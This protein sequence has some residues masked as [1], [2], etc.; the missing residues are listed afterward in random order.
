MDI[1]EILLDCGE[2]MDKSLEYLQ[3]ELRG[4]RTGRANTALLEYVKVEYYGSNT[5]L[6]ELAA[7]SV[8]ESQQLLVKP[9]DP[10][11]KNDIIKAIEAAELGLNPMSEGNAIRVTVPAPSAD[12]R[13]QLVAQVKKMG[14]DA[15]VS[16]RNARRD[17]IKHV[18]STGSEQK[19]SDDD[20]DR[21][22][23]EIEDS[24]KGHVAKVDEMISKKVAEVEDV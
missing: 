2:T 5:D 7:I 16:C 12:R 19:L 1:D 21:A 4:I 24:T 15:K 23:S 8:A 3:K 13:K 9:F 14:E 20:V 22:K 11:A 18:E 10:A 17:A 6:R